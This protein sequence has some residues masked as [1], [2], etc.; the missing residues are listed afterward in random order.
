MRLLCDLIGSVLGV[1]ANRIDPIR[2]DPTPSPLQ[3]IWSNRVASPALCC[4]CITTT[5]SSP[6]LSSPSLL[7]LS[8]DAAAS[9][10]TVQH[11][12][13]QINRLKEEL[14]VRPMPCN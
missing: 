11:L 5:L 3:G 7:R 9:A 14:E 2:S 12:N 1:N 10:D 4:H 13:E 8:V 6:P